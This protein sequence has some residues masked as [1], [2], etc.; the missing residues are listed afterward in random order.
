MELK[1]NYTFP[2]KTKK[3]TFRVMGAGLLLL[4]VGIIF[5]MMGGKGTE[6][7][8][9]GTD[10]VQSQGNGALLS[11]RLWANLL[12]NSFFF[13][14]IGLGAT[15][16]M[17]LKYGAEAHYATVFKRV[18][19]S[20]SRFLWPWGFAFMAFILL[21][22]AFGLNNLY[23]WMDAGV[24][25]ESNKE[26]YDPKI[27]GKAAYFGWFFWLRFFLFFGVWIYIQQKLLKN[28]LEED[29]VGGTQL[30]FKNRILSAVFLVFFGFT[31]SV[32]AWDWM[33]SLDVHWFSTM[34]GWYIFSGIWLSAIIT[35][36]MTVLFLKDQG[37]LEHVNENH[38]HDLG[39]WV[40]AISFLWT[41]LFFCQFMLIWYANLPE[42]V[43]YFQNRME[44]NGYTGIFWT[45]FFVNFAF[46]MLL[47]MSRDSKR[48]RKYLIFVSL[49][50]FF[51]HWTD[52]FV[53][54]MPSTVASHWHFGAIEIGMFLIFLGFLMNRI[55]TALTKAPLLT[56]KHPYLEESIHHHF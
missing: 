8:E 53:I 35:I 55:L 15:F 7:T 41:Y 45:M 25:D 23:H 1:L 10:V 29:M 6:N 46:P 17:A 22:G 12:V 27:V 34:F 38:V 21:A 32:A 54:V 4:I 9:G 16:F 26:M 36:L 13:M 3:F 40:F 28:S 51:S 52:I 47:L 18:Y 56:S 48:N 49:I 14:G 19:E 30:H 50:I 24:Y 5:H 44:T 11:T 42:E 39:K 33:M 20:I 43:T 2:E 37:Y 31:S